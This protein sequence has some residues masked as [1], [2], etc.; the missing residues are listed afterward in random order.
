M[1][2][3]RSGGEGSSDV[4]PDAEGPAAERPCAEGPRDQ[5]TV[6]L[7]LTQKLQ[8]QQI[9]APQMILSMDILLL[10]N[11]ELEN[12]I[13]EEFTA[14]PALEIVERKPEPAETPAG[15]PSAPAG[16]SDIERQEAEVFAQ[17]DAFQSL[18]AF[19]NYEVRQRRSSGGDD[20]RFEA[21][22]NVAGKPTGLREYLIQ[23][24][25]LMKLPPGVVEAA[26]NIINNLDARGYLLST[27]EEI[28]ASLPDCPPE[29]FRKA[30]EAVR[31][32]DP[33]GVGAR[34]LRECLILQLERD[35]QEYTLEVQIIR[36]HLEDLRQNKLP[37]IARDLGR[38]VEEIKEA[39]EIIASLK[40]APGSRYEHSVTVHIQPEV[41]VEKVEG[42]FDV[43]V[44]DDC[45]PQLNISESCRHLLRQARG[46]PAVLK[47][48][49]KKIE[50]AQWLI[51]AVRQRQRT[52]YDIARAIVDY[53]KD[54]M[55]NGPTRL[56]AMKMQTIADLIGVHISTIS[57]AIKGKY[58]QTPWGTFAMRFLFTG[59]VERSDG[60][61]ESRRNIYREIGELIESE[62]KVKPLSDSD[63][64][65]VLRERGLDIARRTV[66]K[67]REQERIPSSRLRKQF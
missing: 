64:A 46:D 65:R 26:E 55:E 49:R 27:P 24:V 38:T 15:P 59:G 62:D 22:A 33:P 44:D 2:R 7:E 60:Q 50:S 39:R 18:P 67:Y 52:I 45:I 4:R 40:P 21:L 14:N 61:L 3:W 43:K 23:Q 35:R 17:L 57:R 16:Q 53:Q 20:D 58:V 36:N 13:Q 8:Q 9:L 10:S 37:K 41:V 25:H 63:I 12:R 54:F 11:V 34:D 31:G 5:G 32:L 47:F 42:K 19:G 28:Q 1:E 51:Q 6:K 56:R 29:D 48:I 30:L 66:T